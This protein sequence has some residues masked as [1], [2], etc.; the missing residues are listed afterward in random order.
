[1]LGDSETFTQALENFTSQFAGNKPLFSGGVQIGSW[2]PGGGYFDV[3]A[4]DVMRNV[5]S[6]VAS[7]NAGAT[8][9]QSDP[10]SWTTW[11]DWDQPITVQA[12]CLAKGVVPSWIDPTVAA[13]LVQNPDGSIGQ[14]GGI[15]T[16]LI[17]A[18]GLVAVSL[19]LLLVRR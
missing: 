19:L 5:C 12:Y 16:P 15:S 7:L 11:D 18:G 4:Q 3:N 17:V 14:P 13:G 10:A 6:G 9:A 8:A 2:A 1:M